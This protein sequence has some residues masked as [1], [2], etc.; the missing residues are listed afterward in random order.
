MI[1][2]LLCSLIIAQTT[3]KIYNDGYALVEEKKKKNFSKTGKQT[4]RISKLPISTIPSSIN[5]LSKDINL[6]SKKYFYNPITIKNLLNSNIGNEIELVKYGENGSIVFSTFGKL[7]SNKNSPVFE[8]GGNIVINP[9]Y[10]YRFKNIPSNISDFPYLDF[11]IENSDK[12]IKYHLNYLTRGIFWNAEFNLFINKKN[13]AEIEGWYY[14]NNELEITYKNSEVLLISGIINF[15]LNE[16]KSRNYSPKATMSHNSS[17][18]LIE[19]ETE[20]YIVFSL[21][22]RLDL[23]SD[24]ELRYNFISKKNI[25]YKTVY[26]INHSIFSSRQKDDL[27]EI[28]VNV[29]YDLIANDIADIQLPSATYNLYEEYNDNIIYIG[30]SKSKIAY[31]DDIIRL[32]T[33]KTN[34]VLCKFN[35][36]EM[37]KGRRKIILN[38][39]FKN[40]KNKDILVEWIQDIPSPTRKEAWEITD[41]NLQFTKIDYNSNL[42]QVAIPANSN[43]DAR[44]TISAIE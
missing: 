12:N 10:S 39:S 44:I 19:T 21:P 16:K 18:T 31:G 37:N 36:E 9:P 23:V 25:T 43:I 26:Y 15:D 1:N 29:R 8:I 4:F 2:F 3:I 33:G 35:I 13:E 28:P 7:I 24:L 40:L 42:F 17:N 32:S 22:E 20:E 30:S 34:E 41:S 38:A 11:N 5:I 27:I 6:I 14:I